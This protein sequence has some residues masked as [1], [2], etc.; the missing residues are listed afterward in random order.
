VGPAGKVLRPAVPDQVVVEQLRVFELDH[1]RARAGGGDD[2]LA[3]GKCMDGVLGQ[4][5]GVGMVGVVHASSPLDAVQRFM[6]RVDLGMIPHILDTIIFVKD[7]E[8]KKVYELDLTVRVPTGMT[9]QDLARP[10]IDVRDFETGRLE[11]EI[12]TFGEENI[13]VPVSK[14]EHDG[15][16]KLAEARILEMMRRFDR[17]AEVE[18]VSH[19]RALVKVDKSAVP[20]LIG[21]GGATVRELEKM[22]NIKIDVEPRLKSLGQDVKFDVGEAGNSVNLLFGDETVGRPVDVYVDDEYLFSAVVGKKARVKVSKRSEAGRKLIGAMMADGRIR[23]L[24][25]TR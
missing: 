4:L 7:G 15:V 13:V 9:E 22:L 2:C 19:G 23:V 6:G 11:Y 20:V 25:G 3:V 18:I 21:K 24:T 12:Y 17:G 1:R 14:E 8:I 5:A 16:K 10:V